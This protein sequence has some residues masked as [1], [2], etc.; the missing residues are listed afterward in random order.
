MTTT[1]RVVLDPPAGARGMPG[2]LAR[3]LVAAA[4][5]GCE[6]EAVVPS[7][8]TVAEVP[9]LARVTR[10]RVSRAA[11][12][13]AWRTAAMPRLN[14]MVHSTTLLAPLGRHDRA[15]DLD[16]TVVTL[17]DLR[18][19]DTPQELPRGEAAWQRAMLRRAARFADGIV[20]PTH[21]MAARLAEL[22]PLGD[23]IR[24]IAGAAPEDF[25]AP[26]DAVGRTRALGF[27]D[28]YVVVLGGGGESAG[29]ARGLAAAAEATRA[30]PEWAVVLLD[31]PAGLDLPA[32]AAA[33][34]L[35][36]V[37]TSTGLGR[38]DRAALLA[39]A[40]VVIAPAAQPAFPWRVLEALAVGAPIVAAAS[41][42]HDEVVLDGGA[43]VD[44]GRHA[45]LAEAV[46]SVVGDPVAAARLR[47]LARDRARAFS[48]R[49]A[50]ERI[51]QLH[52]DL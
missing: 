7:G 23:R 12:A 4:P 32:A 37:H 33:A 16:Q 41:P 5:A 50:A 2:E 9:G 15:H 48:W 1:L 49:G 38:A 51:W 22:A 36:L 29:I 20:V 27:A 19:W 44:A 6:V 14:G 43:R 24:V 42:V 28:G 10:T 35:P 39:A 47:V 40:Q 30:R 11:L 17:W 34:G 8:E 46:A 18:A 31:A 25:A 52:A 3:A 13:T 26:Q 21:G 45:A